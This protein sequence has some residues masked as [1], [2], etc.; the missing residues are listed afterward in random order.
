[1]VELGQHQ[2]KQM[3]HLVD[4]LQQPLRQPRQDLHLLDG[5]MEQQLL[6]LLL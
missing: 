5:V 4:H 1:M 3:F 6:T 2:H